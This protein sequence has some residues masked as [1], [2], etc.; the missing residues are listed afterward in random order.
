MQEF[1]YDVFFSY[2][3]RPLDSELS[4]KAFNLLESYRL[5]KA[6]R[7]QGF[8]EVHRAFRDTE[9]LPVSRILT[10]SI[11]SALRSTNSLVV[12]CSEDTPESRWI[13]REVSVFIELGRADH[14]YPLL[15]S[16]DPERSFPPSLKLWR[17]SRRTRVHVGS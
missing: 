14:I 7:E 9:E 11:D 10:E 4:L 5:P 1:T 2:R 17:T 3:H 13:D 16:G 12:V 8:P 15:I 6:I